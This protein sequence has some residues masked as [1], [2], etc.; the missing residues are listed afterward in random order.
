MSDDDDCMF[1][2]DGDGSFDE[3][4]FEEVSSNDEGDVDAENQYYNSKGLKEMDINGALQGLAK[5]VELQGGELSEWG[6]KALKQQMKL[7]FK[8]AQYDIMTEKYKELLKYI[9]SAVTRNYSEKSINN[10]LDYVCEVDNTE[11]LEEFYSITLAA[12]L[13]VNNERLLFKTNLKLGNLHLSRDDYKGLSRVLTD[14]HRMCQLEDGTPDP[15]KGTQQLEICALE[16]QMFTKQKNF[17]KLKDLYER[18]LNLKSA[19]PRPLDA[20]IIRE[21]GGKMHMREG[22]WAAAHTDFFESFKSYDESGSQRRIQC[23]KYL[24]LANMLMEST[25]NPFD[26]QEAKP[27]KEHPQI[28]AMRNLVGAYQHNDIRQFERILASNRDNIT[29]DPFIKEFIDDLLISIRTQVIL[30]TIKPYDN[31]RLDALGRMLNTTADVVEKLLVV[32]VL[33]G[34]LKGTIDQ[35]ANV[36][37]KRIVSETAPRFEAMGKWSQS[38]HGLLE[39]LQTPRM[40]LDA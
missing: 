33:D 39:S 22:Q 11:L 23:L 19:I 5:V 2:S 3:N 8:M 30:K 12:L 32:L 13:E 26:S 29:N 9:K 20:G 34:R 37:N 6:F 10:I 24:V 18:S 36:F 40:T 31:I 17:K 21:C 35:V 27:Y 15:K 25:I 38:A 4:D 1:D 14:L 28:M 7:Y 16:I